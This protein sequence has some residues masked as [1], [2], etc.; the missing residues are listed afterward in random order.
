MDA[1]DL[2]LLATDTLLQELFHR[3]DHGAFCGLISVTV[4]NQNGTGDNQAIH[5]WKGCSLTCAGLIAE[6]QGKI[7]RQRTID[8]GED[9]WTTEENSP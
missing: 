2:E 1:P 4:D 8:R 5:V 9:Q 6:C 3:F 7:L